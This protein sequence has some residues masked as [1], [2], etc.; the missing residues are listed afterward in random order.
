MTAT[1]AL[2]PAF[3]QQT[4]TGT[5]RGKVQNATNGAY[6]ENALVTITATGQQTK[7]N[8]YGEYEFRNVPAGEV[9]LKA[10][11]TGEPDLQA[12]V[13]VMPNVAVNQDFTFRESSVT[14]RTDDGSIVLDPFVVSAERYRNAQAIALAEERNSINIK[15]VVSVDQFGA[16]PSGNVGEFVKFMPGVMIDYGATNGNNQGYSDNTANGVSVRGFGPEDTAILIDGLPV[17]STMPGNLTRQTGLDQLSINNAARVELIKVATPDMPNNSIG[18][19]VNL[20]TR[21]AFEYPRPTYTAKVYF[22]FNSLNTDFSKTA[23]PTNK[24]TFKTTPGVDLSVTYPVSKTFGVS[25]TGSWAREFSQSYRAQPTWNNSWATNYNAGAFT[26][27]AGQPSSLSNPV[28]TRYQITDSPTMTERQ[29]AN[30]KIDWKP[31]PNQTLRANVQYS[32]YETNEAQRRL[33]FRP[34][35]ANGIVWDATQTV[36]QH[37][38]IIPRL[39][40]LPHVIASAIPSQLKCN[41]TPHSL[42]LISRLLAAFRSPSAISWTSK[43]VIFL[44]WI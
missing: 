38:P 18:G 14:K 27:A 35:I 6:L 29:S 37:R 17:A 1:L 26:N 4:S 24:E 36:G 39:C 3:A 30:F 42:A 16:I 5:L 25:L 10:S 41:T 22:N 43:T 2:S 8:G 23:G 11:Y 44:A 21:T 19:Q 34:T 31:T 12:S 40:Q 33:D 20:V 32:T 13:T 28:L 9:N 7:T 15:N